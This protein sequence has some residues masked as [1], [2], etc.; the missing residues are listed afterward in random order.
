MNLRTSRLLDL[1]TTYLLASYGQATATGLAALLPEVSHDQ[2]TRLLS[3]QDFGERDL[4]RIVKPHARRVQSDDAVLIL[5]DTV[6][7]KPYTDASELMCWHY[8]HTVGRNVKGINLL[9]ALYVSQEVSLPV[10]FHLVHKTELVTDTKTGKQ[11]WQSPVTKNE[12]S[13]Q[14]IQSTLQKQIPFRYVLADSWF[15]SLDNMIF[16]K[17]KARKDFIIPLKDNRNVFLADPATKVGKPIKLSAI[18]FD[19]EGLRTLYLEK[20]PF[21]VLVLRQ[22]FTNDDGSEAIAYLSTSD[23]SLSA[24]SLREIYQKRWK[25]EEYHKSL[26]SNASFSKSPT[27]KVRTQS[28][29][30]FASLVAFVKLEACRITKRTNH[31]ALKNQIYR[32]AMATSLRLFQ[33]LVRDCPGAPITS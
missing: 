8:D 28:N 29:H 22:V 20:L 21:P 14:M 15:S 7:E 32:A 25:I 13:R 1:Y 23:L 24:T 6:E 17:Q 33:N 26:K 5:D 2:I 11:K 16:I 12:I 30:F 27:K 10:A 3:R 18:D 4:W 31:F 19:S 9:S